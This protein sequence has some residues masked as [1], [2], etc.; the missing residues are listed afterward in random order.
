MANGSTLPQL[1]H[2][3]EAMENCI[4]GKK[5]AENLQQLLDIKEQFPIQEEV[6]E[7]FCNLYIVTDFY[8]LI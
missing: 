4:V 5:P 8:S 7:M 1:Q 6:W 3:V 2:E